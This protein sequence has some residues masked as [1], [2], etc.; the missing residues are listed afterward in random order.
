MNT[1]HRRIIL[2]VNDSYF[3]YLLAHNLIKQRHEDI[4]AIIFSESIKNSKRKIFSILRKSS[5]RFFVYR[6]FVQL[7][8][9]FFYRK[10]TVNHL[11]EKYKIN[12]LSIE[13]LKDLE[14]NIAKNTIGLAF[15][16][17]IVLTQKFIDK[18]DKG[19][20]NVHASKLPLD[21][22]ISPVLWAF[23]RGDSE[24][25][26]TIYKMD[27][28]IDSG[29]VFKQIKIDVDKGDSAFSLYKKVC[30]ISGAELNSCF[31]ELF[32][33]PILTKQETLS[34]PSYFS[35][36]DQKFEKMLRKSKRKLISTKDILITN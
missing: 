3:S 10:Y 9:I 21:K 15:N 2:L 17:D 19:I 25:W 33:D 26:S 11:A 34:N 8:T 6:V 36:P 29:D 23:A 13:K 18:F 22:G 24:I 35:W 7:L 31:E 14:I 5:K 20:F 30:K 28:G 4:S 27:A 1:E 16:F 12:T 32:A